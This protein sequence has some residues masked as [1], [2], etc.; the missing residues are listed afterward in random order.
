MNRGLEDNLSTK[1]KERVVHH[2]NRFIK[3]FFNKY[4]EMIPSLIIYRNT[5][6]VSIDFLK[7]E[8]SLL[9]NYDIVI[10]E[11]K[12]GIIQVLG[13]TKAIRTAVNPVDLFNGGRLSK[14]DITFIIPPSLIPD[15][16]VE[17]THNDN[18]S[19]GNFTVIRN[20][21]LNYVSDIDIIA[22]YTAE[23]AEIVIS[24]YSLSMQSKIITFFIGEEND[25]TINQL[26]SDLYNG[27]PYVKVSKLFDAKENI[28]HMET[29][30]ISQNFA[31]L[32]REYQNK[33]G[34]LNNALGINSL[35]VDKESGV[36]NVEANSNRAYTSSIANIKL[37]SR[38]H[39]IDKLNKRFNL[40]IEV[41]YNDEVASEINSYQG[42]IEE[43]KEGENLGTE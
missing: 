38:E 35:G 39:A 31:E 22:H 43:E 18:C 23:L 15:E 13:F 28:Y 27:S 37:A 9:N 36:S 17:I 24:R 41:L 21:T 6:G 7:V 25:E 4:L 19:T 34:E 8:T 33:I 30:N 26:V 12:L 2:R 14:K 20:K 42:K 10:G 29:N 11:N 32:K 3:I 5:E 40:N 16:M 1:I